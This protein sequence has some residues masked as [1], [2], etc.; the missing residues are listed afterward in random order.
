MPILLGSLKKS[1]S[2][3]CLLPDFVD[4][5]HCAVAVL[6]VWEAGRTLPWH[7]VPQ[8]KHNELNESSWAHLLVALHGLVSL[9]PKQA[10]FPREYH[11]CPFG[12]YHCWGTLRWTSRRRSF[13]STNHFQ[14]SYQESCRNTERDLFPSQT[15]QAVR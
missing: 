4:L 10:G 11:E 15:L 3:T 6:S 14:I 12:A 8:K 2:S 9:T 7:G 1:E 5:P 13:M